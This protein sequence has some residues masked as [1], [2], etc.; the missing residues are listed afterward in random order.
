VDI[1][2]IVA[3]GRSD[4]PSLS[5]TQFL[6]ASMTA[7][8]TAVLLSGYFVLRNSDR[9]DDVA[10][11]LQP[12]A[13]LL[14][15]VDPPV[16]GTTVESRTE[17]DV[18]TPSL[19]RTARADTKPTDNGSLPQALQES[20]KRLLAESGY[21]SRCYLSAS[22]VRQNHPGGR[23]SWTM[24]TPGYEGTKCWY[25]AT[26]T[27]AEADALS[28]R[29]RARSLAVESR[30]E[31]EVQ[32]PSSHS[33]VPLEIKPTENG[34]EARPPETLLQREVLYVTPSSPADGREIRLAQLNRSV[35]RSRERWL[36]SLG[37]SRI[38]LQR[39]E[40]IPCFDSRRR[41]GGGPADGG[42]PLFLGDAIVCPRPGSV[43]RRP[44]SLILMALFHRRRHPPGTEATRA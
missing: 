27:V 21:D 22:A 30:A 23:P 44:A 10:V 31:P 26:Q 43:I 42:A 38:V 3:S 28:A 32:T 1:H 19:Q 5:R 24:R 20:G 8:M 34:I 6:V 2:S 39:A 9:P 35:E 33:T 14:P 25:P 41:P 36:R 37:F 11:A 40:N 17:P 4:H 18:P 12:V 29:A 13:S 16:E 15:Q 7:S